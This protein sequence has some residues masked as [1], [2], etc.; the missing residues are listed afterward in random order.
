MSA[1]GLFFFNLIHTKRLILPYLSLS[2]T[3]HRKT[4]PKATSSPKMTAEKK[5]NT[6]DVIDN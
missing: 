5:Q 3:V 1:M 2:P 4:P 6:K